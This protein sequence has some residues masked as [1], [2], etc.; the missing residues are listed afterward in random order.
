M[1]KLSK[2]HKTNIEKIEAE[3]AAQKQD[4]AIAL[5]KVR[6]EARDQLNEQSRH[7]GEQVD[8]LLA[9]KS[10]KYTV[11]L[12]GPDPERSAR[13]VILSLSRHPS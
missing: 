6:S 10:E 2:Q 9:E 4:W 8:R 5:E 12:F 11:D 1:H 3:Y 13:N 7:A